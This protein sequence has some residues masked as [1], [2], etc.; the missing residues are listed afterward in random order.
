M[1]HTFLINVIKQLV[2]S[3]LFPKPKKIIIIIADSYKKKTKNKNEKKYK[4][5][6]LNFLQECWLC[7]LSVH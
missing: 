7:A 2:S 5:I 6:L 1:L 3:R 4:F